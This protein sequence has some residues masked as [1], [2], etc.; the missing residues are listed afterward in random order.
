M[1]LRS[2]FKNQWKIWFESDA[3]LY[4]ITQKRT[5]TQC[6]RTIILLLSFWKKNLPVDSKDFL[7][8][9]R[10]ENFRNFHTVI[11]KPF[12]FR[13]TVTK[14]A[15]ASESNLIVME[16]NLRQNGR[17]GSLEGEHLFPRF[18]RKRRICM[19]LYH[20]MK[21]SASKCRGN[22]RNNKSQKSVKQN[23]SIFSIISIIPYSVPKKNYPFLL[24]SLR[25]IE[26]IAEI[27]WN[28]N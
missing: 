14:F 20:I 4:P 7:K 13:T 19:I 3:N 25:V 22:R 6:K 12:F 23:P 11:N 16:R 21:I 9:N 5:S 17:E 2:R 1:K 18:L 15:D 27:L 28:R 24:N 26:H 8:I 10:R